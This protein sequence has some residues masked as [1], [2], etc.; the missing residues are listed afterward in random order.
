MRSGFELGGQTVKAGERRTVEIPLSRLADHTLMSLTTHVIHGKKDGPVMFVSAAVHGD[1]IIGV[2]II[3][4]VTS[5]RTMS[6]LRGT[7]ILVP[8]V[9]A[10][11]FL[12]LSRYLPDRR[13]L[14]RTFPGSERGSLASQLAHTFMSQIVARAQYGIDL[15]SGAV[16]RENLPQ[17]RAD[18]DDPEV[19]ALAE[20]FGASIMLNATV[21]DG[22]LRA[23]AKEVGCKILL[24]EA[25]EALR[26]DEVAIR[27]GVNGVLGVLRH[28]GMLLPSKARR[29]RIEPVRSDSSH[30]LRA[31]IGGLLRTKKKLG[32]RVK[33]GEAL[34]LI[35]DPL[36]SV[37]EEVK[38]RASGIVIGRTNLPMVNG[39][40]A[41]FHVAQVK[42]L[43]E[44]EEVLEVLE[45]ELDSDPLFDGMEIV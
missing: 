5:L 10:Y 9:N 31:P 30:W 24:F 38:A 21:R 25:G 34:G 26:F 23:A 16:H 17:I 33:R 29:R 2:E 3:R 45:E 22:S 42:S 32:D 11:G 40:D 7:L 28:V 18:L 41:L 44:A 4:R 43:L 39:G 6:R 8:V 27:V 37:E 12:G 14:N 13:D 35:S 36:G 1:E 19:L 20:A 15:H